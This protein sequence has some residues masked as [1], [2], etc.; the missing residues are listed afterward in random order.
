MQKLVRRVQLALEVLVLGQLANSSSSSG[1][2]GGAAVR[3]T[4]AVAPGRA[5]RSSAMLSQA[6]ARS[7]RSG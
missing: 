6:T 2:S 4:V 3:T 1:T 7:G 5:W